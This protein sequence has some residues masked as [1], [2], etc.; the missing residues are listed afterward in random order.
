MNITKIAT[1]LA[2]AVAVAAGVGFV[3]RDTIQTSLYSFMH[4]N[5]H[6]QHHSGGMG[7]DMKNMPGL[8]GRNATQDESD[9]LAVMFENFDTISREVTNL[10]NG[11]RTVT[12]SSDEN[13]MAVLVSHVTGMTDRVNR[14][15]DPQNRTVVRRRVG[16]DVNHL[17]PGGPHHLRE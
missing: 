13:V 3:F 15:D 5:M 7:H 10:P 4:S 8:R 9:E 6:D 16:L 11:I 12:R 14:G 2:L 17:G 1:G